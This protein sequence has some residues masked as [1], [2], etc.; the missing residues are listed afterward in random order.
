M[1]YAKDVIKHISQ[2]ELKN[3]VRKEK[4]KHIHERLLF[5]NHLYLG[6]SISETCERM[7]ISEQTGYNWLKQWNEKGYEGLNPDFGGGRPPKI[8]KQHK[9]QLKDKLKS[10]GNW[11]TSEIRALIKKDFGIAY[12]GRQIIRILRSFNMHYA[13]PYSNDYRKPENAEQLLKDS[14]TL[15]D[16]PEDAVVGFIDEASPQTTDNRQ[17]FWSFSKPRRTRNTTKYRA[18][19]FGFYPI[20]GI[21]TLEFMEN[22]K[23]SSVCEF[24]RSISDKNPGKRIVAFLDNARSHIS[25][26]TRRFAE[27]H[28][29]TLVFIPKYSPDLNPIEFIWKSVR[30]R[31]SQISFIGSEWKFKETI[32]TS[33]HRFAKSKTFMKGWLETFGD[34]FP[35]LLCH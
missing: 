4:N 2:D 11:L 7:C 8:T 29:I 16:I 17:R 27:Q 22:G 31:I 12:S 33:F 30:R 28:N 32:R 13:K 20:N 19:T 6:D 10:K 1:E 21:E 26:H 23:A 24:L 35:N 15:V 5:I 25:A 14:I 9:E 34:L 3:L 18:N